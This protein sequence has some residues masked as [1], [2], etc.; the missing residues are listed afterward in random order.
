MCGA[1]NRRGTPCKRTDIMLN[2][3]CKFHGGMST[4]P[5]SKAG[6]ARARANLGLRWGSEPLEGARNDKVG[7]AAEVHGG[8]G[9]AA[10]R[11]ISEPREDMTKADFC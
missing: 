8:D 4:G 9:S 7:G 5:K 10:A 6:K 2:G 3:R 1:R 11:C